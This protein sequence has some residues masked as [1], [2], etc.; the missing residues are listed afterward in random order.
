M[1]QKLKRLTKAEKD[2]IQTEFDKGFDFQ[3][4]RR[5]DIFIILDEDVIAYLKIL[6]LKQDVDTSL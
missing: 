5:K 1:K 6:H 2:S 4:A 3:A